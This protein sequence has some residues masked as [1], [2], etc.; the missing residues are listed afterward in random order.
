MPWVIY[1]TEPATRSF[2]GEVVQGPSQLSSTGPYNCTITVMHRHLLTE[3]SDKIE[4][5][6]QEKLSA[7][8]WL[9]S[10]NALISSCKE[11]S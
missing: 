10:I 5:R 7:R 11:T 2:I 4:T 6:N 3:V 8:P 9:E 1:Q